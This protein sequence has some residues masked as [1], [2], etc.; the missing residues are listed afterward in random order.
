[1]TPDAERRLAAA[2]AWPAPEY[3]DL[4]LAI[5]QRDELLAHI[6]G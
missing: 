4:D 3:N 2:M 5:A 1:M 6:P